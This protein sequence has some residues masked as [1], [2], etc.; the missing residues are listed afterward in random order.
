VKLLQGAGLDRETGTR[1]CDL[2]RQIAGSVID[3]DTVPTELDSDATTQSRKPRRISHRLRESGHDWPVMQRRAS[4]GHVR[5]QRQIGASPSGL[6]TTTGSGTF[7][8]GE[9]EHWRKCSKR[10]GHLGA[11]TP[12]RQHLAEVLARRDGLLRQSSTLATASRQAMTV[13]HE[14][15]RGLDQAA[16]AVKSATE[17]AAT[18]TIEALAGGETMTE[19]PADAE[20]ARADLRRAH[21]RVDATNAARDK[22]ARRQRLVDDQLRGIPP[23]VDAA[24]REVMWSTPPR[25]SSSGWKSQPRRAPFFPCGHTGAS[26]LAA[27]P[28]WR[29]L[30]GFVTAP[31]ASGST[32]ERQIGWPARLR[33]GKERQR[34]GRWRRLIP[35]DATNR[36]RRGRYPGASLAAAQV[37][38]VSPTGVSETTQFYPVHCKR[39]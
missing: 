1:A 18:H 20:T 23:T 36:G 8:G 24:V 7:D 34:A 5:R 12:E 6:L 32:E 9:A 14:A 19:A 33:V 39:P 16:E 27:D 13:A 25:C 26:V 17:R 31:I 35:A 37:E 2:I 15:Q 3:P 11:V 21:D 28:T 10:F 4:D 22:I 30:L 29:V 38:R